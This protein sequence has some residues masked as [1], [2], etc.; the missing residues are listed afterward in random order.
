MIH[1]KAPLF[2]KK[3]V[4]TFKISSIIKE[5]VW[6]LMIKHSNTIKKKT[7]YNRKTLKRF[8]KNALTASDCPPSIF[9]QGIQRLDVSRGDFRNP[10]G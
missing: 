6:T 4:F 1:E 5:H 10:W 8:N 2:N 9:S 7:L 3:R